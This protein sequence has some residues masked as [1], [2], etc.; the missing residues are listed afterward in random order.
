MHCVDDI[1]DDYIGFIAFSTAYSILSQ[2]SSLFY[3]EY[4]I[5]RY[6][7]SWPLD[8]ISR[9]LVSLVNLFYQNAYV[10]INAWSLSTKAMTLLIL[11]LAIVP[12][13]M[14]ICADYYHL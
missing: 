6:K 9:I 5:S 11:L 14:A 1:I 13:I 10:T 7:C 3:F 8:D 2:E 4:I 12:V